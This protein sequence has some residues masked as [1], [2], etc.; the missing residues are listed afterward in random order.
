MRKKTEKE[1]RQIQVAKSVST[2]EKSYFSWTIGKEGQN[3][4]G[5][6]C[7]NKNLR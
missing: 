7:S 3:K 4:Q 2:G 5:L 1:S 6:E